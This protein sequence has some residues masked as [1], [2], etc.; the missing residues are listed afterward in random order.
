MMA[1]FVLFEVKSMLKRG[2][3]SSHNNYNKTEII[4]MGK[5]TILANIKAKPESV[6]LVKK[7][8]LNII[9]TSRKEI[10][11]INYDLHQDNNNPAHFIFYENWESR[12]LWQ[13]H[14]NNQHIL[15]YKKVTKDALDEV[16][17]TEMTH[18]N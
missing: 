2:M 1:E 9:E 11:C 17:I 14:S 18:I 5:I 15:D 13:D 3:V 12:E 10:G 7:E 6:N 8:L 16:T 4:T